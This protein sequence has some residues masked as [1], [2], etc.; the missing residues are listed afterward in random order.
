MLQSYLHVISYEITILLRWRA[1]RWIMSTFPNNNKEEE[2]W[3][4]QGRITSREQSPMF[5]HPSTK[6]TYSGVRVACWSW[7]ESYGGRFASTMRKINR[8]NIYRWLVRRKGSPTK[9]FFDVPAH[10]RN[11][12]NESFMYKGHRRWI[13]RAGISIPTRNENFSSFRS[14]RRSSQVTPNRVV[15]LQ[16]IQFRR[17]L[18]FS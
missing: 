7:K 15:I 14:S 9:K 6:T 1:S 13:R 17:I 4:T 11:E 10:W 3:Y 2:S 8:K 18:K 5:L 12:V 16:R